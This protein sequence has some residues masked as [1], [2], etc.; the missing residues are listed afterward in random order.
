MN[1]GNAMDDGMDQDAMNHDDH[2]D[3][4]SLLSGAFDAQARSAVSDHAAPPPP[5][6]ADAPARIDVRQRR[7]A[8]LFAPLSAAAAVLLAVG[9]GAAVLNNGGG[10][11]PPAADRGSVASATAPVH[12]K[13]LNGD[14]QTYGVGM[15]VIAYF[16]RTF[17]DARALQKATIVTVNGAR[18]PADWYFER[19]EA[20]EGP[21]EGHL[22][23]SL[24]WPAHAQVNVDISARNINAGRGAAFD[25]DISLDFTTGA[26]RIVSVDGASHQLTVTTDGK[27]GANYPVSLGAKTTPTRSGI[28]VIMGKAEK[29]TLTGSNRHQTGVQYTERLTYDGE[30]LLAAPRNVANIA[31][32]VNSS[33]GSTN[34]TTQVAKALYRTLRVGDVVI[35]ANTGGPQM[36]LANGFGDWNVQPGE[37]QT[38]G[39]IPTH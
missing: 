19:S 1:D 29:A 26:R 17:T 24:Y 18:T 38:G 4:E 37:W 7:R 16:S 23:P 30:F 5:R 6:F 9:V 39:L 14:G 3:L 33:D 13:L 32:K 36:T 35:Y 22:R 27:R 11:G 8:R 2:N 10:N 15:P 25:N 21:I 28:K 31:K 34:L 20:G 12:I